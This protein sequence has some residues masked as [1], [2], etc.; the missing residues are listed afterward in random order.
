VLGHWTL[1]RCY[2]VAEA[3]A[4]Q[5]FA[6]LQ[7]LFVSIIGISVFGEILRFNVLVGAALI[8]VS[9]LFALLRERHKA[10]AG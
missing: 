6:Y 9:G 5:P 4:V 3:S 7:L 2:E 8:T 10:R 1:I